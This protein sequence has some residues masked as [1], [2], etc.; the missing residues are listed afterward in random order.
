MGSN[1]GSIF[2]RGLIGKKTWIKLYVKAIGQGYVGG[3]LWVRYSANTLDSFNM[4]TDFTNV[5]NTCRNILT[6]H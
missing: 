4:N 3:M 2:C 6:I 1:S 5:W